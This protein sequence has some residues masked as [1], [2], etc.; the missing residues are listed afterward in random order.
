MFT[1]PIVN[2]ILL[3]L[4]F[5]LGGGEVKAQKNLISVKRYLFFG[6]HVKRYLRHIF[7]GPLFVSSGPNTR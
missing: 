1:E 3:L 5:F 7:R 6:L 2:L 4:L